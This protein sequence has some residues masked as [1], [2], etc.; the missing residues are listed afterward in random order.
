MSPPPPPPFIHSIQTDV[1]ALSIVHSS[2]RNGVTAFIPE[3]KQRRLSPPPPARCVAA[4]IVVIN[5][6]KVKSHLRFNLQLLRIPKTCMSRVF[7]TSTS[8]SNP[9]GYQSHSKKFLT[10]TVVAYV[11]FWFP[12]GL[13][14]RF[15]KRWLSKTC[16]RLWSLQSIHTHTQKS[17]FSSLFFMAQS[18]YDYK[19]HEYLWSEVRQQWRLSVSPVWL[20]Q[21]FKTATFYET[22]QVF[23][24][25]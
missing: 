18:N 2:I 22:I 23:W 16:F 19:H 1:G 10:K 25:V 14:I 7:S 3:C 6:L 11:S 5:S 17:L 24:S 4:I 12:R 8:L 21:R 15:W 20:P 13:L 9:S